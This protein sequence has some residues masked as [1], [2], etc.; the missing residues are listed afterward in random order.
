MEKNWMK[1]EETSGMQNM[2]AF[3]TIELN[4]SPL[5][6]TTHLLCPSCLVFCILYD[7]IV[8]KIVKKNPQLFFPVFFPL[9][10]FSP[11]HYH[12]YLLHRHDPL[13]GAADHRKKKK[14]SQNIFCHIF[15]SVKFLH[16]FTLKTRKYVVGTEC[17]QWTAKW[18]IGFIQ[19]V[20]TQ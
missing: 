18:R 12:D 7:P 6:F 1:K 13:A 15:I 9:H 14:F 10:F 19:R 3:L 16:V 5:L 2:H 4:K 11:C 17:S 8:I 20:V